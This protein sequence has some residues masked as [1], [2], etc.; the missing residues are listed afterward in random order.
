M[1]DQSRL[2]IKERATL[3]NMVDSFEKAIIC[4]RDMK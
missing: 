4:A 1:G 3:Q 2:I